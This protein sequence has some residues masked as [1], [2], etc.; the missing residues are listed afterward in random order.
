[1]RTGIFVSHGDITHEMEERSSCIS[2]MKTEVEYKKA[3]ED[4]LLDKLLKQST[5]S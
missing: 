5:P 4:G 3:L 1:M 2:C